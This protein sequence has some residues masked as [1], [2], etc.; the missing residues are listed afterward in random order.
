MMYIKKR[1]H[2]D[3]GIYGNGDIDGDRCCGRQ[4]NR[5]WERRRKCSD[6]RDMT[7]TRGKVESCCDLVFNKN[8]HIL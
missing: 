7:I 2:V 3:G 6:L 8:K 1:I 5:M 4:R